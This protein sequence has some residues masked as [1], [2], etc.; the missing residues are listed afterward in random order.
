MMYVEHC[1]SNLQQAT[2]QKLLSEVK[3]QKGTIG[4]INKE[5]QQVE[6]RKEKIIKDNGEYELEIK[7]LEHD[8]AK[9]QSESKDCLSKVRGFISNFHG[10]LML[11]PKF[12][13]PDFSVI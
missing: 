6:Q 4:A 5:I 8:I 2:V 9:I 13:M 7:K 10:I 3:S 1:S 12:L 11:T